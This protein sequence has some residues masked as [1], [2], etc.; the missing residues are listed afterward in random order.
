MCRTFSLFSRQC[1]RGLFFT[2]SVSRLIF[3]FLLQPDPR[4]TDVDASFIHHV[5]LARFFFVRSHSCSLPPISVT[6]QPAM[7]SQL[8][9]D[10]ASIFS[11]TFF[12]FCFGLVRDDHSLTHSF[13]F[14]LS[15]SEWLV[16]VASRARPVLAGLSA[17]CMLTCLLFTDSFI[18]L[19][20]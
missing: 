10:R 8:P 18:A 11:L 13:Q 19:L 12:R 9:N 1:F 16:L 3:C 20:E 4:S 5:I 15:A 14:F 2:C 6:I 7:T 17:C